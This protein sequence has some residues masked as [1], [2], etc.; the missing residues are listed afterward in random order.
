MN[1]DQHRIQAFS[2]SHLIFTAHTQTRFA[3]WLDSMSTI[4]NAMQNGCTKF[5]SLAIASFA[6]L[7][8]QIHIRRYKIES[9]RNAVEQRKRNTHRER[10]EFYWVEC[11]ALISE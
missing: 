3:N 1:F 7:Y 5:N 9:H 10:D 8:S 6:L 2:I 4:E 11:G